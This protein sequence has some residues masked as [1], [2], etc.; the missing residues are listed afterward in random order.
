MSKIMKKVIVDQEFIIN[1]LKAKYSAFGDHKIIELTSYF[2]DNVNDLTRRCKNSKVQRNYSIKCLDF[3]IYY[4]PLNSNSAKIEI[5]DT[6]QKNLEKVTLYKPGFSYSGYG[7]D[8][9]ITLKLSDG[10]YIC[11]SDKAARYKDAVSL[12]RESEDLKRKIAYLE[13]KLYLKN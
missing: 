12:Q 1:K 8:Y 11:E 2:F 3:W 4:I 5:F 13:K 10:D 7:D 9:D 6:V